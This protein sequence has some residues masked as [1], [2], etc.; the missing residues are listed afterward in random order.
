VGVGHGIIVR[1]ERLFD[2]YV[3]VDWSANST[4]KRGRDSIWIADSAVSHPVNPSTRAAAMELV[5][6]I[7]DESAGER[8]LIGFDFSFGYPAGFAAALTGDPTAGWAAVWSWL[9][10]TISDDE[11]NRND[12]L[13]VAAAV[14][15]RL[16]GSHSAAPFWGYPGRARTDALPRTRPESYRPFDEFR[17]AEHRVRA[18]GH[19]PFASWQLAYPGS[20][21]SQMMLGMRALELLRRD[22]RRGPRLRV[23]PFET[24]VGPASA[25]IDQGQVMLA[26]IWPSMFALRNGL[27]EVRDAAQVATMVADIAERDAAGCLVDWFDPSL[28]DDERRVVIA[29]EGWTLGVR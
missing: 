4:P 13:D 18:E 12:R 28:D 7:V 1:V 19:R 26:E 15:E 27:H 11:R 10:S 5:C 16:A 21:G 2:R 17:L 14:N 20:V 23:W 9:A 3:M 22:P 6:S 29:E 8:L 24:G 25:V